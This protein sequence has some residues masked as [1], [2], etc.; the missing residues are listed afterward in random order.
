MLISYNN[1]Y[2]QLTVFFLEGYTCTCMLLITFLS[3][4]G[5][6]VE[7]DSNVVTCVTNI[8]WLTQYACPLDAANPHGWNITNP[9]THQNFDLRDLSPSLSQIFVE[10][11]DSY[12]YTVG[13]AGH[14]I[15]CGSLGWD[16]KHPIGSCQTRI[17]TGKSFILGR[18]N[19][20]LLFVGGELRTEYG[21]GNFCH[22]V[23]APRKT[24][25]T[26][27]C[28]RTAPKS[29]YL[30]VLPEEECEYTFNIHTPKAC[31]RE[32]A[33]STECFTPGYATLSS[34][35]SLHVPSIAVPGEG[36]AY[37]AVCGAV[38]ADNQVDAK[39]S[40]VCPYKAAACL[41]A[42]G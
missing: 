32:E 20:S 10:N 4:Q 13:L 7:R 9:V 16:Y 6:P 22:H 11:G 25:L 3:F 1:Y 15:E 17:D 35:T 24:V 2:D 23:N 39:A 14:Q 18:V 40:S 36:T 19:S 34:F 29:G 42:D 41:V 33:P 37:L 21:N 38:S 31:K 28:N 30:E 8:D 27:V 26:F 5:V 12:N